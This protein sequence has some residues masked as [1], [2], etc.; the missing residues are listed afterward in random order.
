MPVFSAQLSSL[1]RKHGSPNTDVE[2]KQLGLVL[3]PASPS[4]RVIV[5]VLAVALLAYTVLLGIVHHFSAGFP[6][7]RGWR[8]EL[9]EGVDQTLCFL[10]K[11]QATHVQKSSSLR[12]NSMRSS[13]G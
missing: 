6:S 9:A 8:E 5:L 7:V 1:S 12:E 4:V 10:V 11:A 13:P 3:C 2:A